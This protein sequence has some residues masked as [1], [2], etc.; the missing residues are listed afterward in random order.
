MPS[1]TW[2]TILWPEPPPLGDERGKGVQVAALTC[3]LSHPL[4]G[5]QKKSDV[6]E[7]EMR[8]KGWRVTQLEKLEKR[9]AGGPGELNLAP[10][11]QCLWE[12]GY[13]P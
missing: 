12:V 7:K 3:W 2:A 1:V 9:G 4:A 13:C 10:E 11:D 6:M 8:E 5:P